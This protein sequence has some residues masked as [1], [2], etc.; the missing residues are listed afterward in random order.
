MKLT[1]APRRPSTRFSAS[2][3]SM[4]ISRPSINTFGGDVS[5][6]S[7]PALLLFTHLFFQLLDLLRHVLPLEVHKFRAARRFDSLLGAV[8][9]IAIMVTGNSVFRLNRRFLRPQAK[10]VPRPW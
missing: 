1:P 9:G 2:F 10:R 7:S 5:I 8:L 4:F 6:Q 3:A